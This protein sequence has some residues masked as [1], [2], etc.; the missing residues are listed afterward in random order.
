VAFKLVND[1]ASKVT[2]SPVRDAAGVWTLYLSKL[3]AG[4]TSGSVIYV[5]Q[6][7]THAG[8]EQLI[9]FEL[10]Q[11]P[12]PTETPTTKPKPVR[13]PVDTCKNQIVN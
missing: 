2:Q 7:N 4:I 13:P 12:E 8:S 6:T 1:P 5:D 9:T 10:I 11:G 3:P